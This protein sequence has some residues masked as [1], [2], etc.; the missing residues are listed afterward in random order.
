MKKIGAIILIILMLAGLGTAGYFIGRDML[1][2][3]TAIEQPAVE[4]PVEE[5]DEPTDPEKPEDPI[6]EP[7]EPVD[8]NQILTTPGDVV[9]LDS[10][11]GFYYRLLDEPVEDESLGGPGVYNVDL[12]QLGNSAVVNWKGFFDGDSYYKYDDV[13]QVFKITDKTLNNYYVVDYFTESYEGYFTAIIPRT[14]ITFGE[15]KFMSVTE[16][17]DI[18]N[19]VE[20]PEV[21]WSEMIGAVVDGYVADSEPEVY[22]SFQSNSMSYVILKDKVLCTPSYYD[23]SS[24]LLIYYA[25]VNNEF[26]LELLI[27]SYE[28]GVLTVDSAAI[29]G[30]NLTFALDE[31]GHMLM[32]GEPVPLFCSHLEPF[33]EA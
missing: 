30:D 28:D 1:A 11:Q 4:D 17:N 22:G 3:S 27:L 10:Y 9:L 14:T 2:S 32:L 24:E 18:S 19:W 29:L 8:Y 6:E 23:E 21:A 7:D 20:T 15:M 25:T 12:W 26:C 16:V 31:S 33:V 13:S 5:P